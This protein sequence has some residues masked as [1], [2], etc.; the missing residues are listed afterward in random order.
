MN[1]LG[2]NGISDPTSDGNAIF[3]HSGLILPRILLPFFIA[4]LCAVVSAQTTV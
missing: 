3:G 1:D 4:L 2:E